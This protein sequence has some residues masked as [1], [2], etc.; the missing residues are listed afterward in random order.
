[1]GEKKIKDRVL[2]STAKD[3]KEIDDWMASASGGKLLGASS[4]SSDCGPSSG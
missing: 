4:S 1:M 2:D 3:R